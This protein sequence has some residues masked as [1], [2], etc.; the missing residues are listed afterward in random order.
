MFK[1]T[2]YSKKDGRVVSRLGQHDDKSR[3]FKSKNGRKCYCYFDLEKNDYR[4]ATDTWIIRNV[5]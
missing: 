4:T 1:I 5:A 2:Y 3:E